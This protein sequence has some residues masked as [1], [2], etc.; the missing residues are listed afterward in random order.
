MS[1]SDIFIKR[2]VLTTVFGLILMLLGLMGVTSLQIRQYPK[3]DESVITVTTIYPGAAADLI[4]GFV[5]SPISGA[6]S[7]AEGVDYVS[8]QS[9]PSASVVSVHMRLGADPDTA[10]TEVMSKVQEVRSRLPQDAQDPTI[11]KGTGM[12]FATMYLALQN[13]NMTPEQITEYI[14]RVIRPRMS[15]I[16]G[17]AEVQI[18]GAANY[19]MRVWIDP[20]KL[21]GRGLTAAEVMASI[22]AAN[23]L[24]APGKTE[25]ALTAYPITL[26]STLQTPEAFGAL[27]ISGQGD[28]VVRLRDVARIELAAANTDMI[29]EFNGERGTFLGVFPTPGANPLD[30]AANVRAALPAIQSSLPDGMQITLMYDATEQ[31]SASIREVL[32]TI[33]EATLIVSV[34]I[35]LFMGSLRSVAMPVAAIPLS[36]VGT[37]FLLFVMGYSINL[38]TLLA[39]VLAIGIVVDDAIVVVENVQRHVDDGMTPMQATF[40]S[41]KELVSPII[42]TSL[43]LVAVFMPLFFT[44][45]LTGQL[46][47]EFAVTLA[48]A[49]F[50]SGVVALTVSPMMSARILTSG[51]HSRFQQWVDRNFL[52]LEG[53]YGRR[54]EG[55]LSYRPIT[56]MIMVVLMG[57]T[58]YLFMKTSTELAPEEDSGALLAIIN[59]PSYATTD[60]TRRYVDQI[61]ELTSGLPEVDASFS[62]VGFGGGTNS[63]FALWALT[64]WADRERSQQEVQADLQGRIAPLAGMQ[65]FVFAPPSLPGAGGGLPITMVIQSTGPASQVYEVAE[66]IRQKAQE[67]GRFI[68]VQNSLSFDTTQVVLTIDRDR[69]AA[70][71]IPASQIGAT[72]SLLVGGGAIGQF[73]RDSNSYDIIMQVPAEYRDN[74]E[75]LGDFRLRSLTGE[76]VPL[77][78]VTSVTTGVAAANIEQF[79]QLNAATISALPIPGVTT[80]DGLAQI[81]EI[82]RPLLPDGFFIDYSGQSRTEKSEGAGIVTAFV[83][84]L[85]VIYLVL[86]AQ[87]ESFRDPFIILMS[88]PLAIFGVI[89]PLNVGLGSL[90]IYTQIGMIALIGIITKHGI[91]LVEFA[92]QQRRDLGMTREA[93]MVRA[94]RLRLRPILM[95]TIAT[96]VGVVPLM[97]A[98]G[99]GAAARF[100][101]GLVIFSGITVGTLFTLFVVPTVYTLISP[102]DNAP[103]PEEPDP[104]AHGNSEAA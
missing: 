26:Q 32:R 101:M 80:G 70:L 63:G 75:R 18:M 17:V 27:P 31:I 5:T 1:L 91:L 36:L 58:G 62:V 93:A 15:T 14:E 84:A 46:F 22:N 88:V 20:L 69:A 35:L 98:D 41:M 66:E 65:A 86:A 67:S 12:Q 13:P 21:A 89:A 28:D 77:S 54:V 48:G 99:A 30:T 94:A 10:L 61:N 68:V 9:R 51:G 56:V 4:Q 102:R 103:P 74:P 53:W 49:V 78:A 85:L 87:F 60:Y 19:A 33:V 79:N 47:R 55:S 39:L 83:L 3:V 40:R 71:N 81:E 59:G 24:S 7:T 73:D 23:F 92:N 34:V 43:T 2:P 6:V 95:T 29:V 11:V 104:T 44:G 25:G 64:D 97:T 8:T 50:L 42:A 52:R 38:L 82:A 45:G 76:M 90:N 37:L 57:V 72:L 16:D 100:A 96:A